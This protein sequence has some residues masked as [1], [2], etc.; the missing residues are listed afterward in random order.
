MSFVVLTNLY[1]VVISK[2]VIVKALKITNPDYRN[3]INSLSS[4]LCCAMAKKI[5]ELQYKINIYEKNNNNNNV[6]RIMYMTATTVDNSIFWRIVMKSPFINLPLT[7]I[8]Y[9]VN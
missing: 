6:I 5:T 2:E 8:N 3:L 1:I 7:I 9:I 4:N